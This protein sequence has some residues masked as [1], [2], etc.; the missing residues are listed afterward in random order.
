VEYNAKNGVVATLIPVIENNAPKFNAD[1]SVVWANEAEEVYLQGIDL[2]YWTKKTHVAT[3]DATLY[4]K[5]RSFF[6]QDLSKFG[7]YKLFYVT[8]KNNTVH[9]ESS[10]CVDFVWRALN[11]LSSN[12]ICLK[13]YVSTPPH[14]DFVILKNSDDNKTVLEDASNRDE[15][16]RWYKKNAA[17]FASVHKMLGTVSKLGKGKVPAKDAVKRLSRELHSLAGSNQGI[18]Y[19]FE[20]EKHVLKVKVDLKN[21]DFVK[22]EYNYK[23]STS[24][25]PFDD[26]KNCK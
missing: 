15:I 19:L 23:T 12:G 9:S 24:T 1:G 13:K 11:F 6:L 26:D 4:G 8:G 16:T 17:N 21:L 22:L 2:S 3:I 7:Q 5:L 10:T 20:D 14:R 25:S 18:L